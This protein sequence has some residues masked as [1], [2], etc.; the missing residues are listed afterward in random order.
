MSKY[1]IEEISFIFNWVGR[2]TCFL[3]IYI[4]GE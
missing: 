3:C 2:V 1:A 4:V